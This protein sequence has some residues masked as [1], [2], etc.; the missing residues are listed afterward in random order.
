MGAILVGARRTSPAP[1][2]LAALT[3][4]AASAN[5]AAQDRSTPDAEATASNGEGLDG[6]SMCVDQEIANRLAVKRKRR[7]NV[8]RL[9]VKQARH[10][11]SVVGGYY[12][13]DL[14]SATYIVGGAYTYH[15]TD[16]V[17]V[18]FSGAYTRSNADIIR[19]LEDDRG[20]TIEEEADDVIM[21]EA[22]LVWSPIYGKV[23]LGGSVMRFDMHFDAGVGV[24]DADTSRGI[25]GVGGVQSLP[26]HVVTSW[27]QHFMPSA[28]KA[29]IDTLCTQ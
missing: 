5:A 1:A 25:S 16:D 23:R 15:M 8:D 13:S 7:Q 6:P 12:A 22:L 11:L 19:T 3:L 26:V 2:A 24:V 9:F 29:T 18:E 28:R 27:E 17:G 10:E 20:V 14:Y 21:A 4:L